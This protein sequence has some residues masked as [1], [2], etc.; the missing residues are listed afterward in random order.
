MIEESFIRLYANDFVRMAQ[1]PEVVSLED[2]A[3][4]KRIL[5]ARKHA[6]VMDA[7]K[8]DGHLAALISRLHDEARRPYS[9][10]RVGSSNESDAVGRRHRFLEVIA[11]RLA[12]RQD[13]PQPIMS[14]RMEESAITY[15]GVVVGLLGGGRRSIRLDNGHIVSAVPAKGVT[16]SKPGDRMS[17]EIAIHPSQGWLMTGP[18]RAEWPA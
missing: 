9:A 7:R 3:L 5:E 12:D 4:A 10:S 6:G 16:K 15:D 8:G 13:R 17:I 14:E 1:R 18:G 2:P 11:D